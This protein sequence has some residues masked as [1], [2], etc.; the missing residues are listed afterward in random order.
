MPPMTI[1]DMVVSRIRALSET[2]PVVCCIC[3]EHKKVRKFR[4]YADSEWSFACETC[5]EVCF[6]ES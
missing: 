3:N 1:R 5:L 2:D 4:L 6:K